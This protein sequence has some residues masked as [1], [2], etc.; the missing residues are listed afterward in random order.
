M[1]SPGAPGDKVHVNPTDLATVPEQRRRRRRR[2]RKRRSLD[3][4]DID[5]DIQSVYTRLMS[6]QQDGQK[7]QV[8]FHL[9]VRFGF[10]VFSF[11]RAVYNGKKEKNGGMTEVTGDFPSLNVVWVFIF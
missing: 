4:T 8:I 2:R 3:S 1:G 6:R 7:L 10:S 5:F 11:C 9:G